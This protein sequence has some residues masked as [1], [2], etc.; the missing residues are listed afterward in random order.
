MDDPSLN[1]SPSPVASLPMERDLKAVARTIYENEMVHVSCN[2][3]LGLYHVFIVGQ[4]PRSF[5]RADYAQDHIRQKTGYEVVLA[6]AFAP[7]HA[8]TQLELDL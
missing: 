4:K 3:W 6:S 8:P 5:M 7:L 1:P 2:D